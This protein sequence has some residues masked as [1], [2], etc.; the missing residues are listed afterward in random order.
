MYD[1]RVY[2]SSSF[3]HDLILL[4]SLNLPSGQITSPRH[5][6]ILAAVVKHILESSSA[7]VL[8][9]VDHIA[10]AAVVLGEAFEE[11]HNLMADHF[12]FDNRK[13][14]PVFLLFSP[15]AVLDH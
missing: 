3:V 11:I 5:Q 12:D 10:A 14:N 4:P 2:P 15:F 7:A 13:G 1:V 9:P 8:G 6:L